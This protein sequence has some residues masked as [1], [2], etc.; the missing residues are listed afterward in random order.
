MFELYL[1]GFVVVIVGGVFARMKYL[2]WKA[3]K[4]QK[5]NSNLTKVVSH[6][7]TIAK[8]KAERQNGQKKRVKENV[9]KTI[10]DE[11][12]SFYD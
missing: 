11:F 4:L 7:E 10:E 9:E 12:S 5:D 6:H 8:T 3:N 1:A 2:T